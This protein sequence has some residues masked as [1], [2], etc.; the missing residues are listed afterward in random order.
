MTPVCSITGEPCQCSGAAGCAV[1]KQNA[2]ALRVAEQGQEGVRLA[3]EEVER[4]LA[5]RRP[6]PGPELREAI[7]LAVVL[8]TEIRRVAEDLEK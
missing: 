8:R 6:Y 7:R 4:A 5:L 1:K 3:L 2:R